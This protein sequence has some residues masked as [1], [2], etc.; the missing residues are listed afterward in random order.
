MRKP[1]EF[2]NHPAS[3]E[4]A[5]S[6]GCFRAVCKNVTDGDTFDAFIDLGMGKYAYDTIRLHD[7]DTA[8]IFHPSNAAER[9]HGLAAKERVTELLLNKPILIKTYKDAETF[10]RY[11]AD[12]AIVTTNPL[13]LTDLAGTLGSEGFAKKPNYAI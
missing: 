13:T 1:A 6:T 4:M 11:V 12:V 9:A 2:D 3:Y 8:E 7:F 5:R 10:G